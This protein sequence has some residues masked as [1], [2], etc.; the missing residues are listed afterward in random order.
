[1]MSTPPPVAHDDARPPLDFLV[2]YPQI[3]DI[4]DTFLRRTV[5][6]VLDELWR[7]SA[8]QSLEE[9]PVSADIPYPDLLHAQCVM[10]LSLS[11]A[12][13]FARHHGIQVNRDHLIAAGVLQ[14]ASKLVEYAPGTGDET[15][16]STEIGKWLPQAFWCAHTS[17][18]RALPLPVIHA[19]LS[20]SSGSAQL[21]QTLE[22]KILYYADQLDVT[23]IH[24]DE[25]KKTVFLTR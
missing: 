18:A 20:R 2:Y 7:M 22:G 6:E 9:V 15:L 4:A 3:S 5:I 12:D 1:M 13:A 16:V 17:A 24:K 25:W 10:E 21:P 8:W 23:A 19:V 11:I 14:N